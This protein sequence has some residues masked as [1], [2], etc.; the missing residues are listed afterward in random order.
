MVFRMLSVL[1]VVV[2]VLSSFYFPVTASEDVPDISDIRL[3]RKMG[4]YDKAGKYLDILTN[5]N[6]TSDAV[7]RQ[8]YVE[9]VTIAL[10]RN[11]P[12]NA[13]A[14]ARE[15]VEKYPDIKID[16]FDYPA[17]VVSCF[18]EVKNSMFAILIFSITPN[19]TEVYLDGRKLG[20]APVDSMFVKAGK[21]EL[22][23]S[24]LNYRD[25]SF[26]VE[27]E[28]GS[29]K[30]I[31]VTL[32]KHVMDI[33]S[34]QYGLGIEGSAGLESLGY[35]NPGGLIAGLGVI[36]T[37]RPAI[38]FSGG[39]VLYMMYS[40]RAA[41]NVGV[42]YVNFGGRADILMSGGEEEYDINNQAIGISLF[43]KY[44]LKP[45]H[46]IFLSGGPELA[47]IINAD[48]SSV[49]GDDLYEVNDNVNATQLLMHFGGGFE[50][51]V[52]SNHLSVGL[53]YGIG[54]LDI[55]KDESYKYTSYKPREF[56][57][58]LGYIFH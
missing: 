6:S 18:D 36:Q 20:A 52:G 2:V 31:F 56:R 54:M 12:D 37:Y 19:G 26:A 38:R 47:M 13:M 16:P 39:L 55:K 10:L 3:L 21:Y 7:M 48:I 50:I 44:F 17:E 53:S 33:F 58:I 22:S 24:M 51:P 23:F 40:E 42:R 28:A 30:E 11:N 27:I 45:R 34:F 46:R 43:Y 25:E 8:V 9:K 5:E 35:E 14:L 29:R 4:E 1:A 57:L 49:N 15:A 32:E 41:I